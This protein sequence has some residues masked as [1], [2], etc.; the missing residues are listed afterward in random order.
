MLFAS[1]WTAI[2]FADVSIP[3]KSVLCS[4][5]YIKTAFEAFQFLTS[6]CCS[7]YLGICTPSGNF[8][9]AF[10]LTTLLQ[11]WSVPEAIPILP[12]PLQQFLFCYNHYSNAEKL[13]LKCH[14][15]KQ[16]FQR[17]NFHS[18]FSSTANCGHLQMDRRM[19]KCFHILL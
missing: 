1:M 3:H 8:L 9:S 6:K 16:S 19:F 5:K 10:L 12:Q 4:L 11:P 17:W 2:I 14:F 18:N 13:V 7:T 15:W